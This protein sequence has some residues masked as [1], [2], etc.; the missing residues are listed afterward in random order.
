MRGTV[1]VV[2]PTAKP[3]T[4][5]AGKYEDVTVD[6]PPLYDAVA[7]AASKHSC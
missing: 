4:L 2:N 1:K 6:G 5:P 7:F 3:L